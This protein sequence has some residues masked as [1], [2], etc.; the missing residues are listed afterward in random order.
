MTTPP[1]PNYSAYN[2]QLIIS[3]F[4]LNYFIQR[5]QVLLVVV[6]FVFFPLKVIS[7]GFEE[8]FSHRNVVCLDEEVLLLTLK[9]KMLQ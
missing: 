2:Q 4:L 1:P 6:V 5:F 7:F 9:T 8:M 3:V